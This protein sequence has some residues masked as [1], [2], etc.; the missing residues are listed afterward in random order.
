MTI[1]IE[2]IQEV[3]LAGRFA[4]LGSSGLEGLAK[5]LDEDECRQLLHEWA[6]W[7]RPA[8]RSPIGDWLC[9]LVMAGRGYGKTRMGAEWV[10][11]RVEGASPLIAAKGAPGR[12]ALMAKTSGDGRAATGQHLILA[13]AVGA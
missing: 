1:K 8:Q 9:W 11:S 12:I 5:T 6:F 2:P 7:C 4:R 3:S 13:R 10:R